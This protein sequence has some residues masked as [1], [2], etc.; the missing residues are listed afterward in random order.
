MVVKKTYGDMVNGSLK[1]LT[2]ATN[3]T[4]LAEGSIARALVETTNLEVSRLQ[5][6]AN[7]LFSNA[8]LSTA[9]GFFLD[10][11]GERLGVTRGRERRASTTVTDGSVRFYV[12]SGTLG[13]YLPDSSDPT[14]GV[15]PRGTTI[16]NSTSTI[17]Y[18]VSFDVQFPINAKSVF[19]PVFAEDPGSGFNVGANQLTIHSLNVSQV[20][21]TNDLAISS[22][23][24]TESDDEYRFRLSR[25]ASTRFG[26]NALSVQ[27]AALSAPGVSRVEV[28]QFARGAGTFDVLLIPRGNRVTKT[29][30]DTAK[31][32]IEQVSAFG[33]SSVV[34]E[35]L[36][37]PI[38]L[39]IQLSYT[40]NSS[41]GERLNARRAA[42]SS[43]LAYIGSIPLGGELVINQIRAA[44]VGSHGSIK[45]MK[46]LELCVDGSPRTLRNIQLKED[47][48]YIPDTE[49]ADPIEII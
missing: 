20:K 19:V 33:I 23:S 43:V 36:Y 16:R 29:A 7:T 13:S 48:L 44:V 6:F 28:L 34:R 9:T 24:D 25:A 5:E 46:I 26:A 45:D 14:K 4:Y 49:N 38:K 31:R 40:T 1:Y 8:F 3:I 12:N 18:T 35:P 11:F 41:S 2:Q 17:E 32:N 37:V 39:S 30:I 15:I 27:L 47:E 42:E 21:V 22:G 10:L